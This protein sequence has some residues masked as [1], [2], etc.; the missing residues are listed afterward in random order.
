MCVPTPQQKHAA[1]HRIG[2]SVHV[3]F[4]CAPSS[5]RGTT[6]YNVPK[7]GSTQTS[8]R[9][10]TPTLLFVSFI[11]SSGVDPRVVARLTS[12]I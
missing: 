10:P 5:T 2:P 8:G 1:T 12:C 7:G 9:C 11:L 3:W 4:R 6:I